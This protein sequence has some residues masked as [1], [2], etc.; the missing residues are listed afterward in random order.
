M[1]VTS[2][3][4]KQDDTLRAF[5]SEVAALSVLLSRTQR[6]IA[7]E[8]RDTQK[9]IADAF[10]TH[11]GSGIAQDSTLS[12][13]T[14]RE[15]GIRNSIFEDMVKTLRFHTIQ[16]R[17]HAVEEAHRDTLNW[18]YE[19]PEAGESKCSGRVWSDFSAWLSS[20]NG[21]Y[22]ITGKPASGKSTLMKFIVTNPRTK[23][24]LS[25]WGSPSPEGKRLCMASFFFWLSG[26]KDQRS[27]SGLLRAIIFDVLTQ[28]PWLLPT[29]FP[30]E[31]SE[32]Y[33][34]KLVPPEREEDEYED[35]DWRELAYS[36]S[37][38]PGLPLKEL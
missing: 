19:D 37:L 14:I 7:T 21:I 27:Q 30:E 26:T 1:I 5:K 25:D 9:L 3:L 2:L 36:V 35:W 13:Y 32:R 33:C 10:V 11:H 23:Q 15:K 12:N 28:F 22:W 34:H 24:L 20:K 31:W 8:K 16:S 18:V 4:Q 38:I 17:F 6:V 29:V